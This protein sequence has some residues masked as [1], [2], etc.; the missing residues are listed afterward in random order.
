MFLMGYCDIV[1][2]K[3]NLLKDKAKLENQLRNEETIT[4]MLLKNEPR[5]QVEGDPRKPELLTAERAIIEGLFGSGLDGKTAVEAAIA[6]SEFYPNRSTETLSPTST[7]P[8]VQKF[9]K[10]VSIIQNHIKKNPFTVAQMQAVV[11][12]APDK[13]YELLKLSMQEN[14]PFGK[15]VYDFVIGLLGAGTAR[16]IKRNE[17]VKADLAALEAKKDSMSATEYSKEKINLENKLAMRDIASAIVSLGENFFSNDTDVFHPIYAIHESYEHKAG[18]KGKGIDVRKKEQK[19]GYN[20]WKVSGFEILNG[21]VHPYTYSTKAAGTKLYHW[22]GVNQDGKADNRNP[23]QDDMSP[24][25]VLFGL[26]DGTSAKGEKGKVESNYAFVNIPQYLK[27]SIRLNAISAVGDIYKLLSHPSD[28]KE[29][30]DIWGL[31]MASPTYPDELALVEY[32][33]GTG[34]IPQAVIGNSLGKKIYESMPVQFQSD[35]DSDLKAKTES[36]LGLYAL[37]FMHNVKLVKQ[38]DEVFKYGDKTANLIKIGMSKNNVDGLTSPDMI[39]AAISALEFIGATEPREGFSVKPDHPEKKKIRNSKLDMAKSVSE[40]VKKMSDKPLSFTADAYVLRDLYRISPDLAYAYAGVYDVDESK[41]TYDRIKEQSKINYGR[42]QVDAL[43]IKLEEV[44]LGEEFYLEYDFTVS[45]RYMIDAIVNP[46]ESKITRFLVT[47]PDLLSTIRFKDG[48]LNADDLHFYKVGLSQAFD[49]DPDKK[50]DET[51]I[52]DLESKIVSISDKG[53]VTFSKNEKGEMTVFEKAYIALK[54]LDSSGS[55]KLIALRDDTEKHNKYIKTLME[56]QQQGGGFHTIQALRSLMAIDK[57][58][59]QAEKD[60]SLDKSDIDGE[61]KTTFTLESDA[62]TSGMIISLVQM[63]TRSAM[64]LAEKGGVY[65]DEAIARWK[66]TAEDFNSFAVKANDEAGKE[67]IKPFKSFNTGKTEFNLTHG[68]L[69]E[70]SAHVAKEL[71]GKDIEGASELISQSAFADV[72]ET[73]ARSAEAELKLIIADLK[74]DI[75]INE[76]ETDVLEKRLLHAVAQ[77]KSFEQAGKP[78]PKY[79]TKEIKSLMYELKDKKKKL[80]NMKLELAVSNVVGD[81]K[82]STAKPPTMVYI[83]GAMLSSIRKKLTASVVV[84][85]V[86]DLLNKPAFKGKSKEIAIALLHAMSQAESTDE[87]IKSRISKVLKAFQ[88]DSMESLMKDAGIKSAQQAEEMKLILNTMLVDGG[89]EFKQKSNA[90][91]E[92]VTAPKNEET[93]DKL[94]FKASAINALSFASEATVGA[95]FEKGFEEFSEMDKFRESIK[96]MEIARFTIFKYQLNKAMNRA[97]KLYGTKLAGGG[98]KLSSKDIDSMIRE[99]EKDGFGHSVNDINGGKQPLYSR[100]KLM[101]ELRAVLVARISSA[102]RFGTTSLETEGKGFKL[103]TGASGVIIVHSIDG[104][105]DSVSSEMFNL[106]RIYDGSVSS[107]NKLGEQAEKYNEDFASANAQWNALVSQMNQLN[108]EIATL[109]E[110]DEIEATIYGMSKREQADVIN[111]IAKLMD[112]KDIHNLSIKHDMPLIVEGVKNRYKESVEV[113]NGGKTE[114]TVF[115]QYLSDKF[116]GVKRPLRTTDGIA[117]EDSAVDNVFGFLSQIVEHVQAEDIKTKFPYMRENGVRNVVDLSINGFGFDSFIGYNGGSFVEIGLNDGNA[118]IIVVGSTLKGEIDREANEWQFTKEKMND[119][120]K[121]GAVVLKIPTMKKLKG[122]DSKFTDADVELVKREID[123]LFELLPDGYN[124]GFMPTVRYENAELRQYFKMRKD[125]LIARGYGNAVHTMPIE[126]S[127]TNSNQF[128]ID[129]KTKASAPKDAVKAV[130]KA[131]NSNK[132]IGFGK[133]WTSTAYYEQQ[134]RDAGRDVNSGNYTSS[135]IVFMSVNGGGVAS[136]QAI[137]ATVAEAIIALD[138]GAKVVADSEAYLNGSTYNDGEKKV[139]EKLLAL[140]YNRVQSTGN[141]EVGIWMKNKAITRATS[142]GSK[143]LV[144]VDS[145]QAGLEYALTNPTHTSP[146]G[147]QWNKGDVATRK[148]LASGIDYNG[149]HYADVEHAYQANNTKAKGIPIDD[150]YDYALMVDLIE[151]KLNTFPRLIAGID[152]Q[153]GLEYLNKVVH[154][155]TGGKSRWETGNKDLFKK[156]LIEAYNRVT[157]SGSIMQI[158]KESDD[159]EL[160][161]HE[162]MNGIVHFTSDGLSK[163]EPDQ[164]VFKARMTK[165]YE[166]A[167][168]L[169]SKLNSGENIYSQF[170]ELKKDFDKFLE[171]RVNLA[172]DL[173]LGTNKFQNSIASAED[174]VDIELS[175]E[176]AEVVNDIMSDM[177]DNKDCQII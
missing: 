70:F 133:E 125:E 19:A 77:E 108:D 10:N 173:I 26:Q 16:S 121:L 17:R 172:S 156:A 103:N 67:I 58:F 76:Q 176:E 50:M 82:R 8:E 96:F 9:F 4:A 170:A 42:M 84:P 136:D 113:A 102:E 2:K 174:I 161:M 11:L 107:I 123:K 100:D 166:T 73:V 23:E 14:V 160:Y 69:K 83:Y 31:D 110:R 54:N 61:F 3:E 74:N 119:L 66:N 89:Y 51:V 171:D 7:D 104:F 45:G 78:V 60:G 130:F 116:K 139:A 18:T 33:Y 48:T 150:D 28:S 90:G 148:Y 47:S 157:S 154:K 164:E 97:I 32:M 41:P 143:E 120:A 39:T 1:K 15:M 101:N 52:A 168:K 146:K 126:D 105:V 81:I 75:A 71:K 177:K 138:A 165:Y 153:G 137:E 36:E 118:S 80:D 44:G 43:V 40:R 95:A 59:E 91:F 93:V 162:Y 12:K 62:I 167:I 21:T 57:F 27:D 13:K 169:I 25:A 65:T 53:R 6:V 85:K 132:F 151:I 144:I 134:Y 72:Y 34:H 20:P 106:I 109:T 35:I 129:I 117:M 87:E 131:K 152:K 135:D 112:Y 49:L 114:V 147:F 158:V 30:N 38:N 142:S 124:I 22:V 175:P 64:R 115:H 46:Q 68:W 140:G 122:R 128:G 141:K 98:Y 149:K 145:N 29:F 163:A 155:P 88:I 86:Y 56:A 111:A 5:E 55:D 127:S 159:I 99:I 79:I 94:V 92:Y 63:A 37:K 24:L